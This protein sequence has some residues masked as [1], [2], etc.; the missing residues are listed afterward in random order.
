MTDRYHKWVEW[1]KKQHKSIPPMTGNQASFA[2]WLFENAADEL[3]KI[4]SLQDVFE[5]VRRFIK[6]DNK[7]N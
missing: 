1:N 3:G 5:S 4:G 6:E 7:E 2:E